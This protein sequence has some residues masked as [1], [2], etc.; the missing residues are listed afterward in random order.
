MKYSKTEYEE[1]KKLK[2]DWYNTSFNKKSVD[3][4]FAAIKVFRLTLESNFPESKMII[5]MN[6]VFNERIDFALFVFKRILADKTLHENEFEI[7]I[8]G[9]DLGFHSLLTQ[10]RYGDIQDDK[11]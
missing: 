2:K 1:L 5:I 9:I 11:T 7:A 3:K 4:T 10:I 6:I 8:Q